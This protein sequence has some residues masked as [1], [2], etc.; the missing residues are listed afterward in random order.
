MVNQKGLASYC[1]DCGRCVADTGNHSSDDRLIEIIVDEVVRSL[2]GSSKPLQPGHDL[3]VIPLGVSNRHCHITQA[4]LEK[5]F[6]VGTQLKKYRDLYQPGEFAAEQMVTIIGSKMRAIQNVR[7][8]GPIRNYDQI[9][10]SLTDAITIGIHP[11]VRNSGDLK[12]AAP[13]T[14]V[15]PKGSVYFEECA[16]IAN[17]HVHFSTEVAQQFGVEAGDFIKVRIGG[18]K[19]TVFENV[20]VRVKDGWK[21]QIHLDTDD[22]NAANVRCETG[23]EFYGKM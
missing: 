15:G 14:W 19:G 11:P 22:A 21:M 23:V 16:I 10:L 2:T 3:P 7:I 6:G 1:Q 17:R 8:L 5:L 18:I 9:E 12:G 20:L 4:T 13:L